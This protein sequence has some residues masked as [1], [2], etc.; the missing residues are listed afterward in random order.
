MDLLPYV[1]SGRA[2]M[3][4]HGQLPAANLV[5][6][7]SGQQLARQASIMMAKF[8]TYS[9]EPKLEMN[10]TQ[11]SKWQMDAAGQFASI[12]V[13]Q[14]LHRLCSDDRALS[15]PCPKLQCAPAHTSLN[16]QC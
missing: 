15:S 14:K 7:A 2:K 1:E 4:L 6:R 9:D 8:S 3:G 12:T 10:S 11:T 5:A 13:P 16:L